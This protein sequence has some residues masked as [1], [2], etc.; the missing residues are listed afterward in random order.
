M[1][2]VPPCAAGQGAVS[3]VAMPRRASLRSHL[4]RDRY[5]YLLLLPVIAWFLIFRYGP[6]YGVVIAFKNYRFVDGVLGSPWIGFAHFERMLT[7]RD[8]YQIARNTLLLSVLQLAVQFPAPIVLALVLNEIRGKTY[9]R[10]CQT[11]LY[12]PHFISWVVLA[13]IVISVLSPSTG[14]VNSLL[15]NVLGLKPV[16]FMIV[17]GWWVVAFVLSG[18]W[19]TAG[20]GTIIYLAA[21]AGIDPQLY[22]AARIDGA[23]RVRQVWHITLPGIRSTAVILLILGLGTFLDVGFE[24]VYMLQNDA[25]RSVADVIATYVYRLGLQNAQY[26]YTTAV[27]L[28]QSVVGLVLIIGANAVVKSLGGSALW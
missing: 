16:N 27:G 15:K 20:W 8:F 24:Q 19:K 18:V 23:G 14:V 28:F 1:H 25:V 13:G 26:S 6:M 4:Y 9:K 2:V 10:A 17:P 3:V 7:S 21:I 22:E 11:L 12:I 5:L